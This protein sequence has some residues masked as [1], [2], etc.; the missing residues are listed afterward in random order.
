[1]TDWE[2]NKGKYAGQ[3]VNTTSVANIFGGT[4]HICGLWPSSI[5][6]RHA[7]LF[8]AVVTNRSFLLDVNKRIYLMLACT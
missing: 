8:N 2:R 6:G 5:T 3:I 4:L 1:M 7:I